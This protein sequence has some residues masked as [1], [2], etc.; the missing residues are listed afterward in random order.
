MRTR[1]LAPLLILLAALSCGREHDPLRPAPSPTGGQILFSGSGHLFVI[2]A[3][4]TGLQQLTNEPYGDYFPRW[5][6]DRSRIVFLRY[7]A[8]QNDS[9][10]VTVIHADG[11][12]AVRLTHDS[13]DGVPS[14]SPDGTQIS[15]QRE[16]LRG[17]VLDV[18]AMNADGTDPHLLMSADS[19]N[20]A[21]GVTWTHENTLLGTDI[22]GLDLQLSPDATKLTRIT[23]R[24]GALPRLSPD[25]SR[26]AFTWR[27]F[28]PLS[29]PYFT[30]ESYI[31]T[32]K[33]DGSDMRQLT[34]ANDQ[35]PC[36]SPDGRKIAYTSDGRIWIM[37]ADGTHPRPLTAERSSVFG[38]VGDWK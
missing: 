33:R 3:D 15:Y 12:N 37:N 9:A 21:C 23:D 24:P 35:L 34:R 1:T 10:N 29:Y 14:W 19:T 16:D 36:W 18:W 22:T 11:T 7:Y 13:N 2:N 38:F 26:I 4:G 32:V 25:G 20:A 27:G 5:S 31:Y 30:G 28:D 6:P 8:S 17:V